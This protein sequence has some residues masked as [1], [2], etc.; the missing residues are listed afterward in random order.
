MR[1][2]RIPI[3]RLTFLVAVLGAILGGFAWRERLRRQGRSYEQFES[4]CAM[5]ERS[6][7]GGSDPGDRERLRYWEGLRR[8][9]D[10]AARYP[11]LQVTPDPREPE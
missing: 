9:Y 1:P 11:W 2:P 3:R 4:F 5:M 7:R 8:K 10:Q 6:Y